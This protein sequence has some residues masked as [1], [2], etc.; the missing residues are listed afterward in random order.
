MCELSVG[1]LNY[2]VNDRGLG[3]FSI[4]RTR[5]T[6]RPFG[7]KLGH[8]DVKRRSKDIIVVG[9]GRRKRERFKRRRGNLRAKCRKET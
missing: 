5:R 9:Y 2:I 4:S 3:S 8:Q 7:S 6:K 1:R